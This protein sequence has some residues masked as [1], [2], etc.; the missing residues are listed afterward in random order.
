VA[1]WLLIF[2]LVFEVVAI[3]LF[4]TRWQPGIQGVRRFNRRF[5]N[6]VM[7]RFA[8]K[9]RWYAS[10]VHH[11]GRK[12]GKA[13][14][15]PIWAVAAGRHFY[16]PLPYGRDVDWCRNILHAGRCVLESHGTRYEATSPEIVDADLAAGQIPL[17]DHL[18]FSTYG[19]DAYLRLEVPPAQITEMSA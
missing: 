10:V 13:Y 6:P 7:M 14:T 15:T 19:V 3:V 12:S 1:G 5:L 16:I 11:E 8:G 4:R 18:R 2:L 17:R 9:G